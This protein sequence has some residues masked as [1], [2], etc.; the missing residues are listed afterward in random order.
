[1]RN[2]NEHINSEGMYI[3]KLYK[4]GKLPIEKVEQYLKKL[5][6][7]V[8]ND[9]C[10]I[11]MNL[12]FID[13]DNLSIMINM[14]EN[15]ITRIVNNKVYI[16]SLRFVLS[17]QLDNSAEFNKVYDFVKSYK[18]CNYE[19]LNVSSNYEMYWKQML[20]KFE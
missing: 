10:N 3:Y 1:M 18:V 4:K 5:C 12:S 20:L 2:N 8:I 17:K 19:N 14:V 11:N 16:C 9:E 7:S 15:I 6:V 13:Y